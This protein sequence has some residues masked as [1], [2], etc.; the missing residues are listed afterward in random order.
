MQPIGRGSAGGRV[1]ATLLIVLL[2][3][4]C[5]TSLVTLTPTKSDEDREMFVSGYEDIQSVYIQPVNLGD[6]AVAGLQGLSKLDP[7]VTVD[8]NDHQVAVVVDGQ[9]RGAFDT[10]PPDRADDWG[11]LTAN[12]VAAARSASPAISAAS[13]ETIYS[14]VFTGVV[15][16]LDGFSR[17]S[18][19]ADAAE[20]RA[21]REGFG[22]VGIRIAVQ[23]DTVHIVSI[24]HYTPAE[25]VG[26]KADDL[27]T[28]IDGKPTKGLDQEAVVNTLRGPV[29]SD[30]VLTISRNGQAEPLTIKVTRAHIV[31]ESVTYE[32]EG[33]V[34]H[35]RIY[36]FNVET[37]ESLEKEI[38]N[39]K[40][41]IGPSLRGYVLDLRGNPGGVLDQ[42]VEVSD[43]FLNDGP[44]VSTHGRHPDSHQYFEATDGDIADGL[45]IVVLVN[46]FSAS[47][48]EIVAAALQDSGRAVV[49]GSNSYGKGTVQTLLSMP[50][51]GELILTWARFHAPS[52]YTLNRLGVLPS[53]CTD[54]AERDTTLM[55]RLKQGKISPVPTLKRNATNPD[56][57]TALAH[58]RAACPVRNGEQPVDLKVALDLLRD[59]S[60]YER[61]LQLATPTTIAPS[62]T[63]QP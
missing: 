58:L 51:D 5:T 47:A 50:N 35:I 6:V 60:L 11:E 36:S 49:V 42:S 61:A 59:R 24:M 10:P 34:A 43:L 18:S 23:D 62:Q 31:P 12:A 55:A 1:P 32:R 46:G 4:G 8:R 7:K 17:Y 16:T 25:R 37:A 63:A 29:G 54:G 27:I 38:E 48:S 45:P 13:S 3:G 44:I 33:D 20:S 2:V 21:T 15:S 26:L 41:E 57:E 56:D 53:I 39:A 30:V 52:G 40:R 28:H 22:G 14:A 9:P 19:A